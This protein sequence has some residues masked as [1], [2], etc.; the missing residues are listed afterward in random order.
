MTEKLYDGDAYLFSFRARVRACEQKEACYR[1]LLDRT[2]FFPCEGGQGA[3]HGRLGDAAVLDVLLVGDELFH[4][5]DA[6]LAIGEEVLGCVDPVRRMRHMRT[7]TAEHILSGVLHTLY[8]ATNVGFHLGEHEVT[9]DLDISLT[10]EQLAAA[11]EETNRAIFE[12]RPVRILFPKPEELASLTYRAKLDLREGV[13]LVEIE[14]VDLCA[15]CAPHV[16]R[17]GECGMLKILSC[18]AHK[19]GSRLCIAVAAD[20]LCDYRQKQKSVH[21]ASVLLSLPE[22]RVAEGVERTLAAL[23]EERRRLSALRAAIR[24]ERIAALPIGADAVVLYP[25]LDTAAL[26]FYAEEGAAHT[27]AAVL[28]LLE[29]DGSC[30][31]AMAGQGD[32]GARA[33]RLHALLGGRG[34]GRASFASGTFPRDAAAVRIAFLEE[35]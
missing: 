25:D 3:D 4:I 14:G 1:V 5:T 28:V 15:C 10:E 30:R 26:R 29:E 24:A 9:L 35:R 17:T 33:G 7:H 21:E 18:T 11:E 32:M 20:A 2:A 22:D 6:P 16:M 34:G 13:R 8:G 19:G 27:G 12:N 23:A 31:Y